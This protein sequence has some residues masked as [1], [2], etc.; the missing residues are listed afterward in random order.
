MAEMAR[1]HWLKIRGNGGSLQKFYRSRERLVH[2]SAQARMVTN[3]KD[4]RGPLIP[5]VQRPGLTY[6][7]PVE[8]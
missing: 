1:N 3:P 2:I 6:R 8:V 5:W 7:K 4:P